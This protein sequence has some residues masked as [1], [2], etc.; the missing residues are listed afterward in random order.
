MKGMS[1]SSSSKNSNQ[2]QGNA[3]ESNRESDL[4]LGGEIPLNSA[5]TTQELQNEVD[6]IQGT[7]ISQDH[8]APNVT[9]TASQS[10]PRKGL[11]RTMEER[12][13]KMQAKL[14]DTS[15]IVTARHVPLDG[16]PN[17][18]GL[19]RTQEE[20]R[21]KLDA[22]QGTRH[23]V[24]S[25]SLTPDGPLS[26]C[27]T[28]R[29]RT[30]KS[31]GLR[32]NED[33]TKF[34][35][36]ATR[37]SSTNSSAE[38]TASTA[39]VTSDL[40]YV[41]PGAY[42]ATLPSQGEFSVERVSSL[43]RG[44]MMALL[45][46]EG[47]GATLHEVTFPIH[48]PPSNVDTLS[49]QDIG[50]QEL[51]APSA[52]SLVDIEGRSQS[53]LAVATAIEE[54]DDETFLPAAVQYDP[55]AIIYKNRHFRLYGFVGLCCFILAVTAVA[56]VVTQVSGD[57][58]SS[59]GPTFAPTS[60]R[61]SLGIE[62]QLMEVFGSDYFDDPESIRSKALNWLVNEDPYQITRDAE[63]LVQRY[64]LVSFYMET[65]QTGPWYS[66]NPP[67]GMEKD[68]CYF[69]ILLDGSVDPF[70]YLEQYWIRWLS[71]SHECQWA[72]VLCHSEKV[73]ELALGKL[74]AMTRTY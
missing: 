29:L 64:V 8:L 54:A 38:T 33:D 42:S 27:L 71:G 6:A 62:Q 68:D 16:A 35:F 67:K 11:H 5:T 32:R 57:N 34:Q 4:Q 59:V 14:G 18:H 55:D 17:K 10:L 46:Q 22:I 58:A 49:E 31:A 74:R 72:G 51:S 41:R 61:E 24:I 65:T 13:A 12:E 43:R 25:A 73:T 40:P 39:A 48:N 30:S 66:C 50:E 70:S 26:P 21:I 15:F 36:R 63:N 1:K 45:G 20:L 2:T 53:Q 47:V 69:Q 7:A 9:S 60:F 56:I 3:M 23:T 28:D 37:T 19:H 44:G 52:P